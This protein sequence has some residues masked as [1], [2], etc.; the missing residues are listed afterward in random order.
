LEYQRAARPSAKRDG[1]PLYRGGI[2]HAKGC[3]LCG[4]ISVMRK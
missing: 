4:L 3:I 2:H 1:A